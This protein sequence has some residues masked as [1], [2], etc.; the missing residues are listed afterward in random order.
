MK[1][2]NIVRALI[3]SNIVTICLPAYAWMVADKIVELPKGLEQPE[4]LPSLP[5]RVHP[6][7]SH[8]NSVAAHLNH[9]SDM[10]IFE[11]TQAKLNE[12]EEALRDYQFAKQYIRNGEIF[13]AQQLLLKIL[14]QIPSHVDT[15][16][17]LA[18]LH[19]KQNQLKDAEEILTEG[20]RLNESNSDFL[21]L[22]AVI[23]DRKEEPEKALAL[24]IKV[25]DSHK[26]DKSY[27][28][29]LGHIYQETG[30]YALARQQYFRLL[31][32][33]PKNPLWLLGVSIALEAEGQKEAALE[34]YQRLASEGNVDP[35]I[36]KYVQERI[37]ILQG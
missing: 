32:M 9:S 1:I 34:G 4:K 37:K 21:R 18:N 12:D 33:E 3:V 22:M 11:K 35:N 26:Q 13:L 20:L 25:K 10:P 15:R 14:D 29:F 5:E 28:A 36:L 24:L 19:L 16:I 31:Q 17:E 23:H 30:H 2:G 7:L 27:M 6:P 8:E